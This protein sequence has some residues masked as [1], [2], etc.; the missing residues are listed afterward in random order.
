ANRN[1]LHGMN[2][3]NRLRQ[4]AIQFRIPGR[5]GPKT[6]YDAARNNFEDAAERVAIAFR[7]VNEIDHALLDFCISAVERRILR[8]R[9]NLIEGQLQRLFR[10]AAKLDYVTANLNAKAPEQLSR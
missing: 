1:R 10:H 6:G 7:L 4:T 3:H 2:R 5:V 9:G 8:D